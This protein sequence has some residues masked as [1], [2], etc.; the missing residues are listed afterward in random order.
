MDPFLEEN[1]I[2][3]HESTFWTKQD[4]NLFKNNSIMHIDQYNN[5]INF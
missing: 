3:V 2:H 1:I 5:K 4:M